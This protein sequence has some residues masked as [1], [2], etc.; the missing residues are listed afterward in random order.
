MDMS[1]N[2]DASDNDSESSHYQTKEGKKIKRNLGLIVTSILKDKKKLDMRRTKDKIKIEVK[3]SRQTQRKFGY[4]EEYSFWKKSNKKLKTI[5][6]K[7]VTKL[8]NTIYEIKRAAVNE[9]S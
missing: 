4:K 7:G 8:F 1:K 9:N 3:K 5:A 6:L 2:S